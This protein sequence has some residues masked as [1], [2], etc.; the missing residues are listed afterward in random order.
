[1]YLAKRKFSTGSFCQEHKCNTGSHNPGNRF[2]DVLTF[3]GKNGSNLCFLLTISICT[4]VCCCLHGNA[5]PFS[6]WCLTAG[7]SKYVKLLLQQYPLPLKWWWHFISEACMREESQPRRE[8]RWENLTIGLSLTHKAGLSHFCL[9]GVWIN[10]G[11]TSTTAVKD[12]SVVQRT[13]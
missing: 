13:L 2:S 12:R 3:K 9:H 8:E 7:V 6:V 11:L 10:Q 5:T 1:M 4:M